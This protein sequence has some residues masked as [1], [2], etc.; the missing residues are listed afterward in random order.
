MAIRIVSN[1]PDH[2][3]Q[4]DL[5]GNI[6]F[7]SP[8]GHDLF[9][10][11][12]KPRW[13][14]P[15]GTGFPLVVFL[16]G[17]GYTTPDQFWQIPM[18]S[19]L[20]Q[21]GYVVAT[22]THRSCYQVPAP[23]FLQDAKAA[24]RFLKGNAATYDI[25]KERVAFWGTSSGGCTALLV[26]LTG[27]DPAFETGDY[28]EESTKVRAVVDC[29]GPVDLIQRLDW[30]GYTTQTLPEDNRFFHLGGKNRE[31]LEANL[32]AISPST[33]VL[34]ADVPGHRPPF[35]ILHGD[36]DALVA[37]EPSEAFYHRLNACGYP[38]EMVRVPDAPHEG[39]FWSDE[40]IEIIFDFIAH[41]LA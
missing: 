9:L 16:Q 30:A 31:T 25:D 28:L 37:Y 4:L 14:S 39:S 15:E 19:R 1:N 12:I 18:L 23:A 13:A 40:L 8:Q 6:R 10:H 34:P 7:A 38:A 21:R 17:S 20:A 5:K 11:L 36:A 24:I 35:L 41:H 22:I 32:R 3:N 2:L 29:F 27:D 33:Y 26:G